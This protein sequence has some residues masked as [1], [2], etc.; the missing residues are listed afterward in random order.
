MSLL[1]P[2]PRGSLSPSFRKGFLGPVFAPEIARYTRFEF[3][4]YDF[5]TQRWGE[6]R[7]MEGA[8]SA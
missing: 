4:G 5:G 6:H 3:C 2:P 1:V 8:L 7:R